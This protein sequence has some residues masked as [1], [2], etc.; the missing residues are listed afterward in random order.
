MIL[1]N[2]GLVEARDA[3]RD[4]L[5]NNMLV[6]MIC[7][8]TVE[9]E[10][11]GASRLSYGERVV[12]I[13]QDG[14]FL[15][16]RPIGHSPANWQPNTSS[17]T[18]EASGDRLVVTAVRT[19]PT[20]EIVRVYIDKVLMLYTGKLR[21]AGEFIMYLDEHEI[22][23]LLYENPVLVGEDIRFTEKEKDLGEAGYADLFGY[24]GDGK[25]VIVEIKRVTASR[26]AVLQL[27]RYLDAYRRKY[28]V[29][30]IGILVAPNITAQA[31]EACRKLGITYKQ[32]SMARLWRM[33]KEAERRSG[34]SILDYL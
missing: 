9:Y 12:M 5:R 26:E 15:V 19:K 23:D 17:I 1:E 32:I 21:D 27:Y 16:H 14:A 4:A 20:R 10:G 25:P 18:V 7:G 2:P 33:K 24:T 34:K 30:A 11:R 3:I 22:R 31:L 28:G 8:C 29:E 13:K 6:V